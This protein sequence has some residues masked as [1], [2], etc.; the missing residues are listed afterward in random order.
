MSKKISL[1]G[2]FTALAFIL[3]FLKFPSPVG[4]IALDS[5]PGFL[6][7]IINPLYGGIASLLGHFF[8]SWNSGFYFQLYHI[9]LAL[10]MFAITYI[11]GKLYQ[12]NKI[13]SILIG[14]ILNGIVSPFIVVKIITFKGVLGIMPMLI[15]A[16]IVNILLAVIIYSMLKKYNIIKK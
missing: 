16:S 13:I 5:M 12:K 9:P 15:V 11:F 1:I 6:L 2:I 7:S 4:S 8:T 14:V 10:A 3:S